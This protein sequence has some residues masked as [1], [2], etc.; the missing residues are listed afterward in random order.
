[1]SG[2]FLAP[3]LEPARKGG[4]SADSRRALLPA[5]V[6]L[7]HQLVAQRKIEDAMTIASDEHKLEIRAVTDE[8]AEEFVITGAE[9]RKRVDDEDV[10]NS[11]LEVDLQRYKV[12]RNVLENVRVI[13]RWKFS[14]VS[15]W[16]IDSVA[17]AEDARPLNHFAKR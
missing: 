7:F 17:V 3:L 2:C 15:G 12:G 4:F 1:M 8:L 11:R 6:S 16:L 9:I 14:H 5:R 13:E 10:S